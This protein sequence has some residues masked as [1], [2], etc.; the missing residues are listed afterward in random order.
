M[1]NQNESLVCRKGS[2]FYNLVS[3]RAQNNR[4]IISFTNFGFVDLADNLI[5]CFKTLNITNYIMVALDQKAYDYLHEKG[6]PTHLIQLEQKLFDE[7]TQNFGTMGFIDICNL[8]PWLVL[9]V[10][11]AGFD[12]VWTDTD[13]VW[14]QV[15][16]SHSNPCNFSSSASNR[17]YISYLCAGDCL[18]RPRADLNFRF[19]DALPYFDLNTWVDMQL[20]S[21][22]DD[23]CAGFFF[24]R[25]NPRTTKFLQLV[26]DYVSPAVDDQVGLRRYLQ[27]EEHSTRITNRERDH[28]LRL[29]PSAL[30]YYRQSVADM[31][32]EEATF[33]RNDGSFVELSAPP[34][35]LGDRITCVS[36]S[37]VLHPH[38]RISSHRKCT[39]QIPCVR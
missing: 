19:Q 33:Q 25:S 15:R 29:K 36:N 7:T 30:E 10:L 20:Q 32:S 35:D 8:K 13:I 27:M 6:Y 26:L 4:I 11:K 3:S 24:A 18:E 16:S 22:D 37:L 9:E 1:E 23:I 12:V 28:E 39:F 17:V 14:L 34:A 2:E 31:S 21:D 38:L 5:A